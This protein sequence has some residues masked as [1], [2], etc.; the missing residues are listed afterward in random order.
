V[1]QTEEL[2]ARLQSPAA[3]TP[4]PTATP[5]GVNLRD[6]HIVDLEGRLRERFLAKVALRYTKGRGSIEVRFHSDAELEQ[7]LDRLGVT[8]D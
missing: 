3:A 4:P 1:R 5:I 7:L 2:V 8:V 6:P